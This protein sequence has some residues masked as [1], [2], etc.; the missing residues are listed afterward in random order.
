M[1]DASRLLTLMARNDAWANAR[2]LGAC[3]ALSDAEWRAP[4]TGFFPSLAATLSHVHWVDRY[5]ID[6]LTEGG[7]GRGVYDDEPAP[8]AEP[9]AGALMAEQAAL[10]EALVRFCEGLRDLALTVPT[11]R[12]ERIVPERVDHLLLHVFQ[13]RIHHRGQAHAMLSGTSVTP[14]QLDEFHLTLDACAAHPKHGAQWTP[15]S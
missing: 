12:G 6:A 1:T 14:P 10:D 2:L 13:H 8:G 3:A 5:Y 4:R 11:D 7:R 15:T 9:S